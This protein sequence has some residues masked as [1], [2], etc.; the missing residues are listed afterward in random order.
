MVFLL[1]ESK[2]FPFKYSFLFLRFL[3]DH[4]QNRG[5]IAYLSRS[6]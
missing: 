1:S 2:F 4:N 3:K 5:R 6:D